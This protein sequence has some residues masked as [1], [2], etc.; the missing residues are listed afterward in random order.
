MKMKKLLVVFSVSIMLFACNNE[1]KGLQFK[2]MSDVELGNLQKD[3]ATFHATAV[4]FNQSEDT[5][6]LKDFVLDFIVDGKDI[7][8]I[9]TKYDKKILPNKEVSIPIKYSYETADIIKDAAHLSKS[10]A[11]QLKG[12]L[13]TINTKENEVST[14]VSYSESIEFI[15]KKEER[16]ENR[17]NRKE[18]K[19]NKKEERKQRREERRENN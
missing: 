14:A 16:I 10:Y 3:N 15:S 8:N 6:H 19:E 5:L 4:F 9:V 18:E 11:V 1:Q 13:T 2:S 17:E 12:D 7:G